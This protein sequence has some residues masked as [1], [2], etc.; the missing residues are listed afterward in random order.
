MQW[1]ERSSQREPKAE[2]RDQML[3][4]L[5]DNLLFDINRQMTPLAR[6]SYTLNLRVL[7]GHE[8]HLRAGYGPFP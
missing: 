5:N 7:L 4:H 2:E 6:R 8:G 1:I 3:C